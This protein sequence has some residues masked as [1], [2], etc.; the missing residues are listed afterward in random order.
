[1]RACNNIF[2]ITAT[3][4]RRTC[5]RIWFFIFDILIEREAAVN[6]FYMFECIS[7]SLGMKIHCFRGNSALV[8]L[9][10]LISTFQSA[11]TKF[12]SSTYL[13]SIL[14]S[15][16]KLPLCKQLREENSCANFQ[17]SLNTPVKMNR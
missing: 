12:Y 3:N 4:F 2:Q 5:I 13:L 1:M 9:Q 10:F 14:I 11:A 6:F 17:P 16:L 8:V 15:L 7:L